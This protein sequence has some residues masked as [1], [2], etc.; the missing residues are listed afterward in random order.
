MA[1]IPFGAFL[2]SGIGFATVVI[3]A[4]AM[5]GLA[6]RSLAVAAVGAYTA[7]IFFA[8]NADIAFFQ[9]ILYISLIGILIGI[10]FKF[11]RLEAGGE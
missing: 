9:P 4:V 11:W 5:V 7:F 1:S 8:T 3:G 2:D 10:G 6:S